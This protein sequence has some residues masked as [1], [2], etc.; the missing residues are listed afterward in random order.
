MR[1]SRGLGDVYKRQPLYRFHGV[2]Q[3]IFYR[4]LFL[5]NRSIASGE[6]FR[7]TEGAIGVMV[8]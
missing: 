3:V 1:R 8:S 2:R 4:L 7:M 6:S 5:Y